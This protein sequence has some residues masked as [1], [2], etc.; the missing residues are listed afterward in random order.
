[1]SEKILQRIQSELGEGMIA[2]ARLLPTMPA[3]ANG[4]PDKE[5]AEAAVEKVS[6]KS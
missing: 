1:M 5:E 4:A 2:S 3:E 6:A